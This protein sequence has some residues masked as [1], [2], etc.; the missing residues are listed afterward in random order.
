M[1]ASMAAQE[2]LRP[3]KGMLV[4]VLGL[5]TKGVPHLMQWTHPCAMLTRTAVTQLAGMPAPAKVKASRTRR[6]AAYLLGAAG[7]VWTP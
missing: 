3:D 1:T 5:F 6:L 7:Q 2:L 4:F